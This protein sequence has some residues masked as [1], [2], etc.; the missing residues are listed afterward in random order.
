MEYLE[1]EKGYE[2]TIG[3]LMAKLEIKDKEVINGMAEVEDNNNRLREENNRLK[4]E[5]TKLL[6]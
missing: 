6:T 4:E 1:K 5:N 2:N 3:V